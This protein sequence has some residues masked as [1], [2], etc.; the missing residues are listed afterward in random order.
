MTDVSTSKRLLSAPVTT[1]YHK[2]IKLRY[3]IVTAIVK[4]VC[5][6]D[7]LYENNKL[8]MFDLSPKEFD[9]RQIIL[10]NLCVVTNSDEF[11]TQIRNYIY[12]NTNYIE[13]VLKAIPYNKVCIVQSGIQIRLSDLKCRDVDV[14]LHGIWSIPCGPTG[15]INSPIFDIF[16]H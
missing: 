16:Y 12:N 10:S 6:A 11:A 14:L 15:E 7:L 13:R 1:R 4:I 5:Q 3:R 9:N 8:S 2:A